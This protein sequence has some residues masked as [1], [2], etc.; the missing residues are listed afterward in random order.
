MELKWDW[1]AFI[2]YLKETKLSTKAKDWRSILLDIRKFHEYP[3]LS[4]CRELT[5]QLIVQN[6]FNSSSVNKEF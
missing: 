1:H 6:K 5:L 2:E 4:D 3:C